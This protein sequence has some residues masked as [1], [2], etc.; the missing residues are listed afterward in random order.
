MNEQI[1][2]S[3]RIELLTNMLNIRVAM[4]KFSLQKI[5]GTMQEV[6]TGSFDTSPFND[7]EIATLKALLFLD[8][9]SSVDGGRL[10]AKQKERSELLAT[11]KKQQ[12]SAE[13]KGIS[14]EDEHQINQG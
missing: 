14:K 3:K 12:E 13:S 10:E 5:N 6:P 9:Q 4:P 2:A 11:L 1:E 8:V 7:S